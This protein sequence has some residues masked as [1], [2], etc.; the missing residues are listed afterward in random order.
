MKNDWSLATKKGLW[1]RLRSLLCL[2]RSSRVL[3]KRNVFPHLIFTKSKDQI[4]SSSS[5]FNPLFPSISIFNFLIFPSIPF[6]SLLGQLAPLDTEIFCIPTPKKK[7]KKKRAHFIVNDGRWPRE[8]CPL[9]RQWRR[10]PENKPPD[11]SLFIVYPQYTHQ[12]S[13]YRPWI[14]PS[15][16]ISD[17]VSINS[18]TTTRLML[19]LMQLFPAWG[20]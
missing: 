11:L 1:V 7:K 18:A 15:N 14:S 5:L 3:G 17:G 13:I 12:K 4:R 6:G 9:C 2:A 16:S 19:I 20:L 8:T 10:Y